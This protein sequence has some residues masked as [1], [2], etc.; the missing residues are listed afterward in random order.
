[1][2]T[3]K[4]NLIGKLNA[5]KTLIGKINNKEIE[6]YPELEDLIITPSSSEQKFKSSKYGYNNVT[7]EAIE[8][9]ELSIIPS[10]ENQVIE[11]I[12]NKV[13][14]QGDSNLIPENIKKGTTIFGINGTANV[15]D[16][17]ITDTRYLFSNNCRIDKISEILNFCINVID[18]SH[19]FYN[20]TNLTSVDLSSFDTSNVTNMAY[21]FQ[22]CSNLESINLNNFNTSK[23]SNMAYMFGNCNNLTKLDLSSFD[24]SN[25]TNMERM[26]LNCKKI[27]SLDLS[28]FKTIMIKDLSYF[29][30]YCANLVNLDLSSF[31]AS[32]VKYVNYIFAGCDN[33]TNLKFGKN[34][35]KGYTAK[36]NNY[37]EHK[38]DLSY[39][40]LLTHESLMSVINNL[41]DLNLTYNVAGGGK[42]YRQS[43][44]LGATNLAK[45]TEEEIAIAT[46]KGW[47]VS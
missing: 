47:T 18:T 34:L 29:F 16:V 44:V 37:S 43:L 10:S 8:S 22:S 40:P 26:F 39:N 5:K 46:N 17:E 27:E 21:M 36:S 41:Y 9:K 12:F 32:N 15:S 23:V 20:S 2:I 42:L 33:L 13:T 25:V 4:E 28:S 19:M 11:G 35:G 30:Y 6:I 14:V 1:M 24:T 38:L 3:A 45:L 31:D 7:V